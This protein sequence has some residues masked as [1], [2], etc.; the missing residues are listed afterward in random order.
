MRLS[1]YDF[2]NYRLFLKE[3]CEQMQKEKS[4]RAI[5]KDLGF[6]S[7]SSIS[8]TI[9]GQRNLL[10]NAVRKIANFFEMDK[11]E[12]RFLQALVAF[13]QAQD[14]QEKLLFQRQMFSVKGF[15][16]AKP[17]QSAQYQYFSNLLLVLVREIIGLPN[18]DCSTESILS[19]L[20]D[21]SITA[22]DIDGALA[23][24]IDL[25]L[26]DKSLE[27]KLFKRDAH[28]EMPEGMNKGFMYAFHKA[29]LEKA[30]E[31]LFLVPGKKREYSATILTFKS[32]RIGEAKE[33]LRNFRNE[34]IARF[35]EDSDCDSV[36]Q[37]SYQLFELADQKK[38]AG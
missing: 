9:N 11:D 20:H 8:M 10:P 31:S 7:H 5:A 36:S 16:K 1:I 26:V 38:K 3:A 15:L 6:A 30:I 24:L 4:L 22:K 13:N 23:Q 21:Q 33:C 12:S 19:Q 28:I 25:R 17:V 35:S 32:E 37:F 34:F 14:E 18:E 27:G 2:Q 29:V